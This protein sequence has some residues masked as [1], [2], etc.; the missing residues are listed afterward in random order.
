MGAYAGKFHWLLLFSLFLAL[1]IGF[2]PFPTENEYVWCFAKRTLPARLGSDISGAGITS[3]QTFPAYEIRGECG[4]GVPLESYSECRRL[5]FHLADLRADWKKALA[6]SGPKDIWTGFSSINNAEAAVLKYSQALSSAK[7][8]DD[9][10]LSEIDSEGLK[11][12]SGIVGE[13]AGKETFLSIH[14][15]LSLSRR[16]KEIERDLS[17]ARLFHSQILSYYSGFRRFSEN[18]HASHIFKTNCSALSN[19]SLFECSSPGW[20]LVNIACAKDPA[21]CVLATDCEATVANNITN[22]RAYL[23]DFGYFW[24]KNRGERISSSL[25]SYSEY[26]ELHLKAE[27]LYAEKLE[28][29]LLLSRQVG[30]LLSEARSERLGEIPVRLQFGISRGTGESEASL[31]ESGNISES[32]AFSEKAVDRFSA[33][34]GSLSGKGLGERIVALEELRAELSSAK[35]ALEGAIRYASLIEKDLDGQLPEDKLEEFLYFPTGLRIISK[36]AQVESAKGELK[37]LLEVACAPKGTKFPELSIRGLEREGEGLSPEKCAN[38]QSDEN[39]LLALSEEYEARVNGLRWQA[40]L[41]A[42]EDEGILESIG[43]YEFLASNG[44]IS[45]ENAWGFLSLAEREYTKAISSSA[46][47]W[48]VS[49]S[50]EPILPIVSGRESYSRIYGEVKPPEGLF[51]RPVSRDAFSSSF[52]AKTGQNT[53]AQ[54]LRE[55]WTVGG[56]AISASP[57]GPRTIE[58]V[59]ECETSSDTASFLFERSLGIL[60]ESVETYS[61]ENSTSEEY[62][63]VRK[64][65]LSCSDGLPSREIAIDTGIVLPEDRVSVEGAGFFS[66]KG[67]VFVL[68]NCSDSGT[69]IGARIIYSNPVEVALSFGSPGKATISATN[70]LGIPLKK[71]KV[72]FALPKNSSSIFVGGREAY[73]SAEGVSF[74]EVD[75]SPGE[76][77]STE[78]SFLSASEYLP[79]DCPFCCGLGGRFNSLPKEKQA[80]A[81]SSLPKAVESYALLSFVP[82]REKVAKLACADLFREALLLSEELVLSEIESKDKSACRET[83]SHAVSD[84]RALSALKERTEGLRTMRKKFP[85]GNFE[86]APDFSRA[87]LLVSEAERDCNKTLLSQAEAEIELASTK[88][89]L[90]IESAALW[91][92]SEFS[93][94]SLGPEITGEIISA[95]ER[96]VGNRTRLLFSGKKLPL[97]EAPLPSEYSAIINSVVAA[98]GEIAPASELARR[99]HEAVSTADGLEGK[100]ASGVIYLEKAKKAVLEDRLL[101]GY[102]LG[103]YSAIL[104]ENEE[105]SSENKLSGALKIAVALFSI[106]LA[107]GIIFAGKAR[108]RRKPGELKG[109]SL[110]GEIR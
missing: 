23:P 102:F 103:H 46:P 105:K 81:A 74:Y 37:G 73:P 54:S 100:S 77:K 16:A 1:C 56:C 101:D 52:Y 28:D 86:D 22:L 78:L 35:R 61:S 90:A 55:I 48:K 14:S 25:R 64:Y 97:P 79:P 68:A 95:V 3:L 40:R 9:A 99:A 62:S 36:Q 32:L 13:S 63:A 12:I 33:G 88:S 41:L 5:S 83:A 58:F 2:S 44:W 82:N 11:K 27:K 98:S 107:A 89:D 109:D 67:R 71:A 49:F 57:V 10:I 94:S 69:A 15:A 31:Y 6:Y 106:A 19:W 47:I 42:G 43:K 30:N 92:Y 51:G 18:L 21:S 39:I 76:T 8:L 84:R 70:L 4:T 45:A 34:L 59:S 96:R 66:E 60:A 75:L 38:S 110:F 85:F 26:S 29:S 20:V 53:K 17:D 93:E 91:A 80:E 87:I 50:E 7:D 65:S 108:K 104:S 72:F 24:D